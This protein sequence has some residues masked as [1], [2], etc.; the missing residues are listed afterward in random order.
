[1]SRFEP[2]Q[3]STTRTPSRGLALTHFSTFFFTAETSNFLYTM[4]TRLPQHYIKHADYT[5]QKY[6]SHTYKKYVSIFFLK[7]ESCL[8]WEPKSRAWQAFQIKRSSFSFVAWVK[9]RI[10]LERVVSFVFIFHV[11]FKGSPLR[12]LFL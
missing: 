2:L 8:S 3:R 11:G 4:Y 7:K 5:Q 6:Y 1:M 10:H 12:F 9:T